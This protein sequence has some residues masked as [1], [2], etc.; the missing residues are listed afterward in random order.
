MGA[1]HRRVAVGV[2]GERVQL[3]ARQLAHRDQVR[4]GALESRRVHERLAEL[5]Q[6]AIGEVEV[7]AARGR[8]P[9]L[10]GRRCGPVGA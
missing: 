10:R 5:L 7:D 3:A 4:P 9:V 6:V 2:G 1:E 8:H